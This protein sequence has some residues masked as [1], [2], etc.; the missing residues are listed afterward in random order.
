[1]WAW[2]SLSAG[3][4]RSR[5]VREVELVLLHR[6]RAM[7]FAVGL[8]PFQD[9]IAAA[10]TVGGRGGG[11][12]NGLGVDAAGARGRWRARA[13]GSGPSMDF[14]FGM[15]VHGSRLLR[16]R[17]RRLGD[18]SL[19]HAAPRALGLPGGANA[20]DP[21]QR[22]G[23]IGGSGG[24]GSRAGCSVAVA[25]PQTKRRFGNRLAPL[26]RWNRGV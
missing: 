21:G 10:G 13:V 16:G 17:A 26:R 24:R 22:H 5:K 18:G 15:P 1:M 9:G 8:L 2:R 23:V 14:V 20:G 3:R 25:G 4:G 11:R 19:R 7:N 6:G 12:C